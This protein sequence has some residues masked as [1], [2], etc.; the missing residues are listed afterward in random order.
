MSFRP[1]LSIMLT[2]IAALVVYLMP[3]TPKL[4]WA[5]NQ[6]MNQ[7]AVLTAPE[8]DT[9]INVY[10]GPGSREQKIGYG[11]SGDRVT[12]L[13]QVGS[14]EGYT[15]NHIRFNNPPNAEGWVRTDYLSFQLLQIPPV[16]TPQ[17]NQ[18]PVST[19][20]YLGNQ[21]LLEHH[22]GQLDG[23]SF[24]GQSQRK[25][26]KPLEGIQQTVMNWFNKF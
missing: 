4:A 3:I 10:L 16:N 11:L 15:W 2:A 19:N 24:Y 13:E 12:V 8:P 21:P 17:M 6:E 20:G 25:A 22:Q 7:L 23:R 14:N 9:E 18:T 26:S 5:N 1:I